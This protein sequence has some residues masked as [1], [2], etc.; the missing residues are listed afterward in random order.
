VASAEPSPLRKILRLLG[1]ARPYAWLVALTILTSLVYAAGDNARAYLIRPLLDDVLLPTVQEGSLD[2]LTSLKEQTL[3]ARQSEEERQTI[4]EEVL[5]QVKRILLA[6]LLIVIGMPLVRLVRDFTT[7]WVMTRLLVDLQL[8]L[9]T[10]M[11]DLPLARYQSGGRG[12]FVARMTSD[13]MVANTAQSLIFGEAVQSVALLITSLSIALY[14]SWQLTVISIFVAPALG[15]V[16]QV[17]GRRIRKSSRARQEQISEV[18]QRL[19][20]MIGGMKIIKAFNAE[21]HEKTRLSEELMR[22]FR[23]AMGV[24]RNR[25]YSRAL[26]EFLGQFGF[27][28]VMLIGIYAIAYQTWGLTLGTFG[29]YLFIVARLRQPLR[30]L[31]R[32]YNSMQDAV[33][34]AD[35]LF[36]IIDAEGEA[37]DA[38]DAVELDRVEK[39]IRY[40][41]VTF[42]YGRESVLRDVDLE[43]AAGEIVALVGRTGAGKTTLADLLL[44]FAEPQQGSVEL[45]DIDLR[46]L[47]RRDLRKLVAVVTQ[48]P[49]LFDT[50]ILQNIRYGCPDASFDE[51]VSAARAANIHEF[52]ESLPEKYETRVGDLG[53][54]LSGGQRQRITIAR[55]ILRNPQVLI[56]DEATSALDAKAEEQVREAI[57]NLMKGRTVLLIAHRLSTVKSAGRIAVLEDGRITM[58]G[59]HDALIARGGLYQEL[60]ELQFAAPPHPA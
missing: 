35:R 40:R 30:A 16:L 17:F 32:I 38:P 37:P 15:I 45:D 24:I 14:L 47:R 31:T 27:F 2:D 60:V 25:V 52:I 36:E 34:A 59:T 54:N 12:D 8:K 21:D 39:C 19:V 5:P 28:S 23:R 44:R 41:N 26:V 43:I 51:V 49:F 4:I 46:R 55:A 7:E 20:Q 6:A 13:T 11:L 10:R 18:V 56:F 48:D 57:W 42:S 29:A 50:T 1:Y 53:A 22:Y 58:T 33:P 9:G 3:D